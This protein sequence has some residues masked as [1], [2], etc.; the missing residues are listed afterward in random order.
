MEGLEYRLKATKAGDIWWVSDE[1]H[2]SPDKDGAFV[3]LV[4]VSRAKR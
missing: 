2:F 4:L 3:T 1:K